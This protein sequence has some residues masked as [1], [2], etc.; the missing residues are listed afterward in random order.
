MSDMIKSQQANGAIA[1]NS[2]GP[3]AGTR[4][5]VVTETLNTQTVYP[6]PVGGSGTSTNIVMILLFG[7]AIAILG[8][9]AFTPNQREKDLATQNLQLTQANTDM[10]VRQKI[11]ADLLQP[12]P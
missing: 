7:A 12:Q 10:Q 4:T 2:S 6:V 3:I 9:L 8:V 1:Q 5:T 11:C